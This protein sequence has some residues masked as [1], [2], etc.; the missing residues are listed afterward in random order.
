[1]KR[2]GCRSKYLDFLWELS[3][4]PQ[5]V[6]SITEKIKSP[7]RNIPKYILKAMDEGVKFGMVM[8]IDTI[9]T[10]WIKKE[11]SDLVAEIIKKKQKL[12]RYRARK[13]TKKNYNRKKKNN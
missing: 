13:R 7:I 11:S 8:G 2:K 12:E 10:I 4:T 3:I 6:L 1:M 5:E 9:K